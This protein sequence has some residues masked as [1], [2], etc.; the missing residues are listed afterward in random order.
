ML[1]TVPV[2]FEESHTLY[3]LKR[4]SWSTKFFAITEPISSPLST[5]CKQ[6]QLNKTG[7][8]GSK[9]CTNG[10]WKVCFPCVMV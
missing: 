3:N 8:I 2:L 5:D 10:L 1:E 7:L 4:F 9:H 6:T